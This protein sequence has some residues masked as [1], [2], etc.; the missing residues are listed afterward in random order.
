MQRRIVPLKLEPEEDVINVE[1]SIAAAEEITGD[2]LPEPEE[3]K[4]AESLA[5]IHKR[6]QKFMQMRSDPIHGSLG[7]PPVKM[8]DLTAEQ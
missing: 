6:H 1:K 8:E 4:K 5:H 7:P 3:E 2:K